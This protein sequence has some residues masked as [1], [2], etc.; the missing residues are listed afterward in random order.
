MANDFN[1]LDD[2]DELWA[3]GDV[4]L[5]L[6]DVGTW[7]V[8]PGAN[9]IRET[10]EFNPESRPV[11]YIIESLV[12]QLAEHERKRARKALQKAVDDGTVRV[13]SLSKALR[14]IGD[15]REEHEEKVVASKAGR[16]TSAPPRSTP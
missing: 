14:W 15:Q 11:S 9:P 3:M 13:R 6:P 2:D 1:L 4:T 12:V 7:D 10:D 5:T 16:P 8:L